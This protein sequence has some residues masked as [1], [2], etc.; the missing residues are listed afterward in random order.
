[1]VFGKKMHIVTEK[2]Q[3]IRPVVPAVPRCK[4]VLVFP[5]INSPS[6]LRLV[7]IR[8]IIKPCSPYENR[9]G[10]HIDISTE[11]EYFRFCIVLPVIALD[12]ISVLVPHGTSGTENADTVLGIVIQIGSPQQVALFV[13]QLHKVSTELGEIPVDDIMHLVAGEDCIFLLYAHP[14][15]GVYIVPVHIPESGVA[16][17]IS[18]IMQKNSRPDDL[19]DF[20]PFFYGFSGSRA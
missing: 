20:S 18:V 11:L 19:S 9:I 16:F 13:L 4:H 2:K 5:S 8:K 6:E 3:I 17:Q 7:Y 12:D 15:Y 1:M 14:P 10:E